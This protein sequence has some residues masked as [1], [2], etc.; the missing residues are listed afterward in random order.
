MDISTSLNVLARRPAI[1]AIE[2]CAAAGFRA[3]DFNYCD[4]REA[5]LQQ[6]WSEEEVWARKI[7]DTAERVGVRLRQMHGPIFPVLGHGETHEAHLAL[8]ERSMRT[9]AILGVE[10]VVFHPGTLP[11]A[12]DAAHRRQLRDRNAA[13][14]QRLLDTSESSG[15]GVALENCPD[16]AAGG[17]QARRQYGAVPDDLVELVDTIGHPLAGICWDTGHG[18]VQGLDQSLALRSL[19]H[20]LKVTHIHDNDGR[21]D[22]H[23]LPFSGRIAWSGVMHALAAIEYQ[24]SCSLEVQ[25]SFRALPDELKEA[26]LRFAYATAECLVGLSRQA[27]PAA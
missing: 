5:L 13:F 6:S 26:Q 11:G 3:F 12:F 7:R 1:E 16:K 18:E 23:L 24:G 20:R 27:T 8:S 21:S 22:Q 10:W 14:V 2:R 25:T 15:V 17:D 19:G 9:A 4:Y